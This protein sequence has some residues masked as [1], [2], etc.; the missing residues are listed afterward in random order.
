VQLLSHDAEGASIGRSLVILTGSSRDMEEQGSHDTTILVD[1]DEKDSDSSLFGSLFVARPDTWSTRSPLSQ[2]LVSTSQPDEILSDHTGLVNGVGGHFPSTSPSRASSLTIGSE[3]TWDIPVTPRRGS[4]AQGASGGNGVGYASDIF[5]TPL[6]D[7][8]IESTIRKPSLKRHM[9]GQVDPLTP[10]PTPRRKR[11]PSPMST[12]RPIKRSKPQTQPMPHEIENQSHPDAHFHKLGTQQAFHN[13]KQLTASLSSTHSAS[14]FDKKRT[15][16]SGAMIDE[17]NVL[18][19][20]CSSTRSIEVDRI[21]GEGR[22]DRSDQEEFSLE[23]E[24]FTEDK[25]EEQLCQ[26]LRSYRLFYPGSVEMG[27]PGGAE[28]AEKA[29]LARHTLKNMFENQLNSAEDEESLWQEE[30]EDVLN[31]FMAWIREIGV[32]STAQIETF[33]DI[34]ISLGCLE[35]LANA[36]VSTSLYAVWPFVRKIT[37]VPQR[38]P[39]SCFG[40]SNFLSCVGFFRMSMISSSLL[41]IT[42]CRRFGM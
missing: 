38:R 36:S 18:I 17:S 3:A 37:Y 26:L 2:A 10:S 42:S 40:K 41:C 21:L 4:D 35:R 24:W 30:E 1:T 27:H 34:Q 19:E 11:A 9:S 12:P 7:A 22:S 33:S 28:D 39:E 14:P 31:M 23:L 20:N 6:G 16:S 29:Q 8:A 15:R 13:A 32:P 25:I 5:Q